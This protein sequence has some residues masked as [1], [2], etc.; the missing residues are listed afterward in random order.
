MQ[1]DIAFI[2]D[3]PTI[4]PYDGEAPIDFEES[5]RLYPIWKTV[6]YEFLGRDGK[7]GN[8]LIGSQCL[9]CGMIVEF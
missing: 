2:N 9:G 6:S 5:K 7:L 3:Y 1:H 4:C 8:I